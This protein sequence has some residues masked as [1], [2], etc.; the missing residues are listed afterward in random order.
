[1]EN[2]HVLSGL[3]RKRAEL[4]ASWKRRRRRCAN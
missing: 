2:E 4:Q 1:M 3:I